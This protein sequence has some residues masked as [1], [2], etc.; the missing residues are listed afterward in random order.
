MLSQALTIARTTFI[1]AVRQPIYFILIMLAGV[2][3]LLTTWST[4]YSMDYTDVAE[5]S[6]DNKLLLDICAAT[7]FVVGTLLGAFIATSAISREIENKTVL[8]VI[9]KPV[10]RPVLILGK[11]A[12]VAAALMVAGAIMSIMLMLCI[13]HG[14]LSNASQDV[15]EPVIFFSLGALVIALGVALWGNILYGWHFTQTAVLLLFPLIAV[16]YGLVLLINAKWQ[17]QGLGHDF[18]PQISLMIACV[19]LA[20]LVMAAIAVAASTRLGQV[21]TIVICM[22]VLILGLMSNFF[23]GSRAFINDNLVRIAS[24]NPAAP[25]FAGFENAGDEYSLTLRAA[26]R[27]AVKIGE[28]V[29]YGPYPNGAALSHPD[30]GFPDAV[31]TRSDAL[32]QPGASAALV[33]TAYDP[34]ALTMTLRNIGASPVAVSRPPTAD[35]YLFDAPTRTNYGAL[36]VWG[37]VPNFQFFWLLDAVTQNQLIPAWHLLLVA[38]YALDQIVIFLAVAILLFQRRDVG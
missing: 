16:A 28:P 3:M 19:L 2:A 37:M 11:Y 14:V 21:M 38:L 22:G 33:I 7:V 20:L 13:R 8:T 29:W 32:L 17:V 9:S 12:G 1:E 34:T 18:K 30:Y 10:A 25:R 36:A 5:V 4:G 31:N 15:D 6:A 27:R 24:A 35:D 23:F 26:A